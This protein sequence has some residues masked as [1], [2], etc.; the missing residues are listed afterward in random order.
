MT[1]WKCKVP[2]TMDTGDGNRWPTK[3]KPAKKLSDSFGKDK[4]STIKYFLH[5]K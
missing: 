1:N 3:E 2:K 4:K 5:K